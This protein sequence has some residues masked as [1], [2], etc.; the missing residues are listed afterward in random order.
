MV[1]TASSLFQGKPGFKYVD[2]EILRPAQKGLVYFRTISK[3]HVS[4]FHL[5][6]IMEW[7]WQS[8]YISNPA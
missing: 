8:F 5:K 4:T 7:K 3:K 6:L 1:T 2:K